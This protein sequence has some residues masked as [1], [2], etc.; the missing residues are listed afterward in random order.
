M[1]SLES[2]AQKYMDMLPVIVV[3][4]FDPVSD[5]FVDKVLHMPMPKIV[6][7]NQLTAKWHGI[8][9]WDGK[10]TVI[11]VQKAIM[12]DPNTLNRI[13]AHEVC[14]AWAYW[15]V[16]R[17]QQKS[18]W[19]RGHSST[20]GWYKAAQIVNQQEGKDFVSETS[21][22]SY[23]AANE[24]L[25]WVYIETGA[26]GTFWAWFSRVT[27]NL[28]RNLRYRIDIA[29]AHGY[30]IAIIKT[31]D[32]RFLL[33]GGKLPTTSRLRE[34]PA[35]MTQKIERALQTYPINQN[36]PRDIKTLV[37]Q[38]KVARHTHR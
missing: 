4:E 25:F 2:I 9:I 24:K 7:V 27:D 26:R 18:P 38:A 29:Q 5:D 32:E 1:S 8:A 34:M 10:T 19:H 28:A 12:K 33:P 20:G 21:D 22:S 13:V 17:S 37:S 16:Q 6:I 14:H 30:P 36:S 35:D 15:M 23:V 31:N 3:D 11:K